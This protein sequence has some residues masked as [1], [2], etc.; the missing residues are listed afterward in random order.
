MKKEL[1]SL[2][3]GPLVALLFCVPGCIDKKVDISEEIILA[4]LQDN[5]TTL[6][7][8]NTTNKPV[9]AWLTLSV[10]TDSTKAYYEQNVNGIFGITTNGSSGSFTIKPNYTLSYSSIKAFSG[11]ICFGT[12]PLNCPTN[13]YPLGTNIFEFTINNGLLGPEQTESVE[14]SCVAGVHSLIIGNLQGNDWVATAGYDSIK[15]FKNSTFGNN[16]NLV[17]VFPTGCTNCTNTQGMQVCSRALKFDTPNTLP[18]CIVS[19]PC[20]K[21]GGGILCSFNGF[22]K[23]K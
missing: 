7:V 16:S 15:T 17:G 2:F 21:S 19:R 4:N 5:S 14:I 3:I 6:L 18:I 9:T 22:T 8:T 20:S 11:N 10:Y 1:I 13:D 23:T 12:Q